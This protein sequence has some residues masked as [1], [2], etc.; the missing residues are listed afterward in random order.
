MASVAGIQAV[1]ST[2]QN[3]HCISERCHLDSHRQRIA[4]RS[5]V[6]P[7][8]RAGGFWG[9]DIELRTA[10]SYDGRPS[11]APRLR[12]E[13]AISREKKEFTVDKAKKLLED[14]KLV[15]GIKYTGLTVKQLQ[16]FRKSLP[17]DV[18]LTVCKNKLLGKAIEGTEWEVLKPA[19]K[20]MNAWLFVHTEEI[21]KALKPYRDIQKELK[22]E[23]DFTGGVF[24]GK[25]YAPEEFKKLE[26]LPTRNEIYAM[27]LGVLES[28]ARNVVSTIGAPSRELVLTLKAYVKKLE[29][30]QGAGAQ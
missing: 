22:L 13:A 5:H 12:V 27:L 7:L 23:N 17:E 25:Y 3:S 29:D 1:V 28:P 6:V 19:M 9:T 21:P 2:S 10:S 14:C 30:E 16:D 15:A 11:L 4:S 18:T 20:G 26:T 8:R 24:E